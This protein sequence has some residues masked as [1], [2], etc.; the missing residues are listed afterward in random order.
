M[1]GVHS[2]TAS[3]QSSS[4]IQRFP[5][6]RSDSDF[7][8]YSFYRRRE[9][10]SFTLSEDESF[11]IFENAMR[12]ALFGTKY[13]KKIRENT[14]REICTLPYLSFIF[15]STAVRNLILNLELSIL[16]LHDKVFWRA[17]KIKNIF[18]SIHYTM[19]EYGEVEVNLTYS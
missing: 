5:Q 1:K 10:C 14:Q 8:R 7:I 6:P 9:V 3:L 15:I 12:S 11:N 4:D 2:R 18:A 17:Q 16:S 19:D 13:K